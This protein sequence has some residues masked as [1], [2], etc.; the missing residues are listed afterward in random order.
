[1]SKKIK[2][3]V[4]T[5]VVAGGAFAA[6]NL[7]SVNTNELTGALFGNASN[8]FGNVSKTA[9]NKSRTTTSV[10]QNATQTAINA[11][12]AKATQIQ[13]NTV[14]NQITQ[15]QNSVTKESQQTAIKNVLTQRSATNNALTR[16]RSS[17]N[18]LLSET[19]KSPGKT[20]GKNISN[21]QL[22]PFDSRG[23]TNTT[24]S[25][26]SN[27]GL[28]NRATGAS[29]GG[30]ASRDSQS[31]QDSSADT[32]PA[33]MNNNPLDNAE[34]ETSAEVET[35]RESVEQTE[36]LN[37]GGFQVFRDS[38]NDEILTYEF[39]QQPQ[40][41]GNS[42]T[43]DENQGPPRLC[44]PFVTKQIE[45]F[46]TPF[47]TL[48]NALKYAVGSCA[49][50]DDNYKEIVFSHKFDPLESDGDVIRFAD[51]DATKSYK[52]TRVDENNYLVQYLWMDDAWEHVLQINP[53]NT[54]VTV[55]SLQKYGPFSVGLFSENDQLIV[56]S[57]R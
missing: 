26:I 50:G 22:T 45:N 15:L 29:R 3:L 2:Y 30:D 41:E 28:S 25:R 6:A 33:V 13:K 43:P 36:E 54:R 21:D 52:I 44:L 42:D 34:L 31:S 7:L 55:N 12:K 46:Q 17:V 4:L 49:S 39:F 24:D 16:Q 14:N 23:T 38:A 56:V 35:A 32:T 9:S 57:F 47:Y 20:P 19:G 10:N 51:A 40:L 48:E 5:L 53:V 11:A 37:N 1:M 18:S 27:G 8:N